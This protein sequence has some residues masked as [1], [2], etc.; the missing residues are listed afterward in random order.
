MVTMGVAPGFRLVI[1]KA[2]PIAGRPAEFN[3]IGQGLAFTFIP[4]PVLAHLRRTRATSGTNLAATETSG[5]APLGTPT[6]V[7]V[8]ANSMAAARSHAAYLESRHVL[9]AGLRWRTAA[10]ECSKRWHASHGGE[11]ARIAGTARL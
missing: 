8:E 9:R 2:F 3:A 4:M 6:A 10:G 11:P 1:A 5:A 7:M